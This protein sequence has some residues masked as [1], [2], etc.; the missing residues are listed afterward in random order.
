[1]LAS[2]KFCVSCFGQQ[3][4][5]RVPFCP[6]IRLRVQ[7]ISRDQFSYEY[8]RTGSRYGTIYGEQIT[9][10]FNLISYKDDNE[11]LRILGWSVEGHRRFE[12]TVCFSL[13]S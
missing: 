9:A 10:L 8:Y 4:P 7:T 2:L 3:A 11:E 1:M 12:R 5:N 6:R 13:L